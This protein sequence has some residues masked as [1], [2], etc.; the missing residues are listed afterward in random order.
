[1][2]EYLKTMKII[3]PTFR[4]FFVVVRLKCKLALFLPE[5]F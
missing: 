5:G 3:E 1:M 2:T 4:I